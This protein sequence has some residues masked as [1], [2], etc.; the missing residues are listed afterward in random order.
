MFTW[1]AMITQFG[2]SIVSG[3]MPCSAELPHPGECTPALTRL[4]KVSQGV[5]PYFVEED[6]AQVISLALYQ[7]SV[8]TFRSSRVAKLKA[9]NGTRLRDLHPPTP[10]QLAG[11]SGK[12]TMETRPKYT[13]S[14]LDKNFGSIGTYVRARPELHR[15]VAQAAALSGVSFIALHGVSHLVVRRAKAEWID[16]L[17][18]FIGL[19]ITF[20]A[21]SITQEFIMTQR[22]G[23]EFF[24]SAAF[25]MF[26]NRIVI[27]FVS[28]TYLVFTRERLVMPACRLAAFPAITNSISSW[29]QHGSLRYI[30]FPI[31]T[32]FKN[33]KIIPTMF[34]N[35]LLNKQSHS[36]SDYLTAVVVTVC[37]I[38][39]SVFSSD[40]NEPIRDNQT[41][42]IAMMVVF[43]FCDA[44]TSTGEKHI[45]G[46]F[47][48]FSN[49]QMML[50][51]ALF[52]LFY[53]SMIVHFT[54]GFDVIYAFLAEHPDAVLDVGCL[55]MCSTIGQYLTY[56]V[57]KRHGPVTLSIMMTVRQV[58]SL[59]TSAVLF[60]H[61]MSWVSNL[62]VGAAF[63]AV[64]MKLVLAA[65]G[66]KHS[67]GDKD[68][69][70]AQANVGKAELQ[71]Y[72][73]FSKPS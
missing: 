40:N 47:S 71:P 52:S 16:M 45:Y 56:D 9:N 14:L 11:F 44:L 39:F 59:Y 22:Y 61:P 65:S 8:F 43:V 34:M 53:S 20:G 41:L 7:S 48:E 51:V 49:M 27:I 6:S 30:S 5:R 63:G 62:C 54:V 25:L 35:G 50:S 12:S 57:I 36:L 24:P 2:V 15:R 1:V 73:T 28:A 26:A 58:F 69:H 37:V 60:R 68:L 72:G 17:V 3:A 67:K 55:S 66:K 29:C 10:K 33:S 46:T 32:L 64:M 19:V 70:A 21:Y 18:A 38:G 4:G 31:Q 13:V 23:S 42:G